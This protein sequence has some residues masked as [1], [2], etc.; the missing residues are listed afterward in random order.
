MA[1]VN[2]RPVNTGSVYRA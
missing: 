1:R 2:T